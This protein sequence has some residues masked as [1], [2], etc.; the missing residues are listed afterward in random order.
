[1]LEVHIGFQK[2][3]IKVVNMYVCGSTSN[4]YSVG[5]HSHYRTNIISERFVPSSADLSLGRPPYI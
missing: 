5:I 1:M 4:N 3:Y 2:Q